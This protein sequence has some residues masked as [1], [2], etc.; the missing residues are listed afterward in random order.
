[1]IWYYKIDNEDF[2]TKN[3]LSQK[4]KTDLKICIILR[5]NVFILR[6]NIYN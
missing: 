5:I 1:M 4:V 3:M 2:Y 6:N